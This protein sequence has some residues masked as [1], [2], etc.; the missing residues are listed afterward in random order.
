MIDLAVFLNKGVGAGSVSPAASTKEFSEKSG[1]SFANCSYP[2][3]RTII[4]IEKSNESKVI[5]SMENSNCYTISISNCEDILP[6]E[7]FMVTIMSSV[8]DAFDKAEKKLI[9]AKNESK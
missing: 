8:N 2:L 5:Q 6:I 7:K 1:M 3:E 9:N 4:I